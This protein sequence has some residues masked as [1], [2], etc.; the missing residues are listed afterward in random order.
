MCGGAGT[1]LWPASTPVRPK[2]F[3]ALAGRHSCF[4]ETVLRAQL[5]WPG[6]TPLVVAGT[7]H[8]ALIGEQLAAIGAAAHLLIEPKPRDSAPAIAA[9]AAWI[10]NR[11]PHA[12]A[13]VLA[14][15]HHIGNADAFRATAAQAVAA[16]RQGF[17]VTL[18]LKPVEPAT[19]YGYIKPGAALDGGAMRVAAFAEKPD[20][21]TA[22]QHCDAGFL[23]NSGMFVATAQTLADE[24]EAHA[25]Q[26]AAAARAA[27]AG[28]STNGTTTLL[29]HAFADA[30]KISIDYA[31]MEKT[32][33]A[34][35][36]PGDFGWSDLGAW[37]AV[38]SIAGHDASGNAVHG[39][40]VLVNATGNLIRAGDGI[41]VAVVGARNLAVVAEGNSVLVAD[42][43]ASQDVKAAV[44]LIGRKPAAA[45]DTPASGEAQNALMLWLKSSA[46]PL[47]WAVGADPNGG[48]H[49]ALDHAG[50]PV[51]RP[52]RARV[53]T[54]QIYVYAAA[55]QLGW[56]GPWRQAAE[57]GMAFFL[58]HYRRSDGLFRTLVA[59]GGSPLDESATLYD[60]AFALFSMAALH[61]AAP[62]RMDMTREAEL[63]HAAIGAGL[64][65]P[66]GGFLEHGESPFQA[67]PHM[68][69]LEAAL[70]WAVQDSDPRWT[71]LSDEI[72]ALC[73]GKFIDPAGGFV[74]EFFDASWRP[75]GG[76]AGRLIE[77]GHQF[78]WAWLLHRWT[79]LRQRTDAAE[80]IPHLIANGRSGIDRRRNVTI[81]ALND[82]G[83]I[84][85]LNAR[86]WP[87]CEWLRAAVMMGD[88]DEVQH[89]AAAV[90]S[91]LTVPVPG[92]WRDV[93]RADGSFID[94]PSPASSLYHLV[95]AISEFQRRG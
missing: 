59:P 44:D 42:L 75:L 1:R 45:I 34:A 2:Q 57:H 55:G 36:V 86:L 27:L 92:T 64:R 43:A 3:I 91:Y 84:R 13:F 25:P 69:L 40:A 7:A 72:V 90:A 60:Q 80:A 52:R 14:S 58:N 83:T 31:V 8:V 5:L 76:E 9:A 46:M 63:L 53:Q 26:I 49:E 70:A 37:N 73:L 78:E 65:H 61:A 51:D 11:D 21:A 74:R 16:A 77:P 88:A 22:Q 87:Q 82:D 29:G 18:G 94:E 4:Q 54:R 71:A 28:A 81:N 23:W 79:T 10:A 17:L 62:D 35:V 15:D 39:D 33:R 24:I 68:H 47:W 95:G 19:A 48:F 66:A 32:G 50:E 93:L 89:A 41:T 20:R 30:P 56:R 85:D 6:A 38:W 67:N 12:V